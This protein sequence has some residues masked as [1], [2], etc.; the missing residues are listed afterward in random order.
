MAGAAREF[1]PHWNFCGEFFHV[2]GR[3]TFIFFSSSISTRMSNFHRLGDKFVDSGTSIE[4]FLIAS[5]CF[6]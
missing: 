2:C 3:N 4:S 5:R 6:D 1:E